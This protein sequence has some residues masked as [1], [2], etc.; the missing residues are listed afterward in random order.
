MPADCSPALA[1]ALRN[2]KRQALHA[3]KLGLDHPETGEYCEWEAPMPDD[4]QN[5]IR[6]L[7]ENEL[8]QA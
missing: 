4:M 2:F 5:L 6:L 7:T 1:E 3:A 8:D